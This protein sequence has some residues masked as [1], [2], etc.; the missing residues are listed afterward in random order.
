VDFHDPDIIIAIEIVG[1][2]CGIGFITKSL[3][4]RYPFVKVP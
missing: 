1:D 2:E 4:E 3:R